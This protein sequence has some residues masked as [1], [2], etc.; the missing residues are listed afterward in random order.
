MDEQKSELKQPDTKVI[1]TLFLAAIFLAASIAIAPAASHAAGYAADS[2][3]YSG[4][5]PV[6][7]PSS[8]IR[9]CPTKRPVSG[10]DCASAGTE[11]GT[12]TADLL[13]TA[14]GDRRESYRES[15]AAAVELEKLVTEGTDL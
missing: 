2:R 8:T 11:R 1:A 15:D 3:E 9:Q 5:E 4:P 6:S 12:N 10:T 13:R 14:K 7:E